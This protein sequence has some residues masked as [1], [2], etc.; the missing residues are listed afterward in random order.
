MTTTRKRKPKKHA[1]GTGRSKID[2]IL[3]HVTPLREVTL[4]LGDLTGIEYDRVVTKAKDRGLH[5]SGTRRWLLV[6]HTPNR[7]SR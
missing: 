7:P 6:R 2:F 4:D 3:D 5:V 1:A